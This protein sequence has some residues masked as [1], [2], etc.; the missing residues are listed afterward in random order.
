MR[1]RAGE[2]LPHVLYVEDQEL[3]IGQITSSENYIV[4]TKGA[5]LWSVSMLHYVV[6]LQLT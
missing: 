5:D 6:V 3:Q 1:A 4:V 2:L